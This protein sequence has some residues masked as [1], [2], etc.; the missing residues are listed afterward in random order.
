M[1]AR[2][3][4]SQVDGRRTRHA[5]LFPPPRRPGPS[6]DTATS[7]DLRL[8]G[9][10]AA[11]GIRAVLF[12]LCHHSHNMCVCTFLHGTTDSRA[13]GLWLL[14]FD[15]DLNAYGSRSRAGSSK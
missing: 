8:V 11:A 3:P 13:L 6:L 9:P 14:R 7:S 5:A 12:V 15:S 10:G 2:P 4:R 1:R